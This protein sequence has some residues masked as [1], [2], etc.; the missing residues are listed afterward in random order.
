MVETLRN[1]IINAPVE[2]V[3]AYLDDPIR[4]LEW[5]TNMKEIKNVSGSGVGSHFRW[6]YEMIRKRFEGEATVV[7]HIPN[8]KIVIQLKGDISGSLSLIFGPHDGGTMVTSIYKYS[9][10]IQVGGKAAEKLV[11]TLNEKE[12]DLDIASIKVKLDD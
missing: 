1:I 10:P 4:L 3:F 7:D 6:V 11:M 12:M 8:K 9:V 5:M 2:K